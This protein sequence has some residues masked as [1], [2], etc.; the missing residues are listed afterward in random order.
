MTTVE[1]CLSGIESA[2][3]AQDGGAQRIELCENL[4][5]GGMTPSLGMIAQVRQLLRIDIHVLIRPR[6]G[7][8]DY[9]QREFQVMKRDIAL[10]KEMG[11][12]GVVIGLLNRDGTVDLERS[13]E[14]AALARPMRV[15]FHRAFDV[16]R[17]PFQALDD[18]KSLGIE[19][20]L[21]SGQAA[22]AISGLD[23][24]RRL[25]AHAGDD[26]TLLICGNVNAGNAARII[27]ETSASEIHVGPA[28]C[29]EPV[30]SKM[31]YL[32]QAV[33]MGSSDQTD[34]YVISQVSSRRVRAIIEAVS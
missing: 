25:Q 8:F 30:K 26:I 21:T 27:A 16:A 34:E 11:V 1:I 31:T 19:R 9:S 33:Y 7:D 6:P 23:L 17:E 13:G 15:T 22:N 12:D 28:D 20:V 4:A 10:C 5:E 24:L 2:A 29:S 14:L 3:A 18:L 32:N